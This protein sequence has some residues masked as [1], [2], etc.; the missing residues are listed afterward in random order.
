MK[1][2]GERKV[3]KQNSWGKILNP[4]RDERPLEFLC[5]LLI[6]SHI[7]LSPVINNTKEKKSSKFLDKPKII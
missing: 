3:R 4:M 5:M 1:G 7:I 2:G 6:L